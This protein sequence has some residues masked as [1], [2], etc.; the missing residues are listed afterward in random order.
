MIQSN[1]IEHAVLTEHFNRAVVYTM[2]NNGKMHPSETPLNAVD[3]ARGCGTQC[4]IFFR[5]RC[6]KHWLLRDPLHI[7]TAW[8]LT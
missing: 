2:P 7:A 8:L 5:A 1:P 3:Q 4:L 6:G